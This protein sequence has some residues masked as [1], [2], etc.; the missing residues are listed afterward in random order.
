MP[1]SINRIAGKTV[2]H[3]RSAIT[4]RYI[5]NTSAVRNQSRAPISRSIAIA[6][7]A[8][9]ASSGQWVFTDGQIEV[10]TVNVAADDRE[11]TE[12]A[13]KLGFSTIP[14]LLNHLV[15]KEAAEQAFRTKRI[16]AQREALRSRN[17]DLSNLADITTNERTHIHRQAV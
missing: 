1:K 10:G 2:S 7:P 11:M 3:N 5:S 4:G 17:F 13:R 16:D 15:K 14:E 6:G 12:L 9:G 8:G